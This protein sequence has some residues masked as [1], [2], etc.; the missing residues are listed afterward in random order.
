MVLASYSF[1]YNLFSQ[2]LI[3]I[4][5]FIFQSENNFHILNECLSLPPPPQPELQIR[6]RKKTLK[7]CSQQTFS[8]TLIKN[9]Q[10]FQQCLN[11]N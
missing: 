9:I 1:I 10:K 3:L 2:D 5:N 4:V 8:R 6:I 7:I 11:E